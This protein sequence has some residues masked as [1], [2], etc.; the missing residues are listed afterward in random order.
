[1][2]SRPSCHATS[3]P[4][5]RSTTIRKSAA[6]FRTTCWT[7]PYMSVCCTVALVAVTR[8]W[9]LRLPAQPSPSRASSPL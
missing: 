4:Q 7:M 2:A 3:T 9:L 6:G 5:T 8:R 1:M